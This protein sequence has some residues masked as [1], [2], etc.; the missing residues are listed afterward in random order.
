MNRSVVKLC[1]TATAGTLLFAAGVALA[2]P[3]PTTLLDFFQPGTQPNE[4]TDLIV[5]SDVCSACHGNYDINVEPYHRWANSLMG[6]AARDPVFYACLDI[7]E[8]D[9]QFVGDVCIRCHSPGGWLEGRSTPTDGSGFIDKDFDG[10]NCNFCHRM[11]DPVWSSDNPMPDQGILNN[12]STVIPTNPHSG[13]YIV[14][15]RD[16]RRGPYDLGMMF[17][18]HMWQQSPFHREALLCATCHD[19]SNPVFEK[20]PDGT[21]L[22]GDLDAPHPTQNKYDEFPLERT[23]S[24]W[25]V[26]AFASG[27]ID[28][29]GRFGGNNPL[30]S[31]CQD[32]HMPKTTGT[33][34]APGLGGTERTD[35]ALH[36]FHGGNTWVLRAIREMYPDS[37]TALSAQSVADAEARALA[38]VQAAS[39]MEL[40]LQGSQLNVH[41]I[42]QTGHKLPSGYPEGRR[43]W[44]NVKFFDGSGSLIAERGAYDAD[45]ALL[46]TSDTKVY[47]AKLGLDAA[48]SQI[49]GLPEGESFHFALNNVYLKDNRIPPRGFDNAVFASVQAAPVGYTYADG[50][51]WD[52]TLYDIPAGAVSAEV[53]LYYQSTSR[54]YIDFLRDEN[55][56]TTRGQDLYNVW[57]ATGKSAPV[58]M[59][60]DTIILQVPGDL[61][62][63]GDV[64]QADLGILLSCYLTSD[65]GDLDGDGD[66]D[67]ADLGLLLSNYGF[68]T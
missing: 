36:E 42:N 68:G 8:Q 1:A 53:T 16:R 2:L 54:E 6:Q 55:T 32:C 27:P 29:G 14:D 57:E 4:L 18:W 38:M 45:N 60:H 50:Q 35:L 28:M 19:V 15:P 20:Q 25:S 43:I 23:Y 47:E 11:V 41:I 9:A 7:A 44:I 63:D 26:S 46:T 40:S 65:C 52:D 30:V 33:A 61:D 13:Q 59:D 58:V 51:Y 48:M 66:T 24:E 10:I 67:Q 56:T 5:T 22:P 64:D 31:S 21:Y 3:V 34:C 39:D 37:E 12:L 49:T 62:G 17:P